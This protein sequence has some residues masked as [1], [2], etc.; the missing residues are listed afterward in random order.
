MRPAW[1]LLCQILADHS[2]SRGVS[3]IRAN[4]WFWLLS[5]TNWLHSVSLNFLYFWIDLYI[6]WAFWANHKLDIKM[7]PDSLSPQYPKKCD[8]KIEVLS[9][10]SALYL[11]VSSKTMRSGC[12]VYVQNAY[13]HIHIQHTRADMSRPHVWIHTYI[14]I[15]TYILMV[16]TQ[17]YTYVSINLYPHQIICLPWYACTCIYTHSVYYHNKSS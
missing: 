1:I 6:C 3:R 9:H 2:N 17:P 7:F 4:L 8:N 12:V 15:H 5:L 14:H 13:S 16:N 10:S 11:N